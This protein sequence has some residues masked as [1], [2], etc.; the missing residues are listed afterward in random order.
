MSFDKGLQD[1]GN[2]CFVWL[3]PDGGW[4]WSNCG[5]VVGDG[6]SLMVDTLMDLALTREMLDGI[7]HVTTAAPLTAV[8]NTHSDCDHCFGNELVAADGVEIIASQAAA[9]LMTQHAV[10]ELTAMSGLGGRVGE[11]TEA[12]FAPFRIDDIT[13]TPPTRTFSDRLSLHVG[14]RAVEL[15]EVGPAHTAGDVLIHVPDADVLY[16]GDI[17]F[18]DCTPIIWAGPPRRWVQACDLILDMP[19]TTIVPGHG[20][21][22]DKTGVAGVR[23][24]LA[25]VLT[26]AT[27]RF[28]DGLTVSEA[29][30]SIDLGEYSAMPGSGRIAQN[31]VAVYRA[32][33]PTAL[34]LT[35][36]EVF[37]RIAEIDAGGGVR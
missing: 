16:A 27:K 22:T 6:A 33:D 29:I 30:D 23:D 7:A 15:I 35:P 12:M 11:Y 3:Q 21:V 14:G 8:V 18:I 25:F 2:G 20:P 1:L 17:L 4:G 13:V 37:T 36:I 5:L 10:D 34:P 9:E 32:L 24:Y 19:V 28:D 26:E 31:V